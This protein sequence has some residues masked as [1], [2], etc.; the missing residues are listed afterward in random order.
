MRQGIW[1]EQGWQP[2]EGWVTDP[3]N[4]GWWLDPQGDAASESAWW[5]P[6]QD[7]VPEGFLPDVEN[8]GWY[9]IPGS[10]PG[11]PSNWWHDS[12]VVEEPSAT[13]YAPL[14][15]HVPGIISGTFANQPQGVILHG[16][17][18][19][20]Q[21]GTAAEY[22]GTVGYV[23]RG[24]D[25]TVG[26][27][28]TIG[29]DAYAVHMDAGRWGWSARAASQR[30][31]AVEFAQATVDRS[32]SDAQ[33]RAFCHWLQHEALPV[34]PGLP[35]HFPSHAEVE[36][37]GLTGA[38][39][40]K[41]DV[42]PGGDP[43]LEDLRRRIGERL[44]FEPGP[45]AVGVSSAFTLEPDHQFSFAE[46][47]PLI[48]E[49]STKYGVEPKI[50][51]GMVWQESTGTNYRVHRDGTG[52]FLLGYDDGGLLPDFEAWSGLTIGRGAN[53]VMAPV[54]PQLEFAAMKLRAYQD[55]YADDPELPGAS[56]AF[57]GPRAWHAGGGYKYGDPRYRDD[58]S[59]NS[60]RGKSYERL[61]RARIQELGL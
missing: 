50:L 45:A 20:S 14:I 16:S 33:V 44:G 15:E 12:T 3:G 17:R 59:R 58:V 19:G 54:E 57:V 46:L 24:T 7:P 51:A 9:R 56:K 18:S 28:A 49:Y 60:E 35:M 22:R 29:D 48:Q 4:P 61:I 1:T 8:P 11:E 36:A 31:L 37:A 39:D 25:G 2:P 41:T 53:A 52:H 21:N 43:R 23:S 27:H 13:E 38:R 32:I 30:F 5:Q 55:Y 40:G 47:W 26:W 10:D 34:W 6:P 42:Y